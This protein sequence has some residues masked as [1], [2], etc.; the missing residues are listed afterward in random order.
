MYDWIRY[1]IF[2]HLASSATEIQTDMNSIHIGYITMYFGSFPLEHLCSTLPP[3]VMVTGLT[4]HAKNG[5]ICVWHYKC[6]WV[7]SYINII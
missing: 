6:L 2:H 7:G 3:S 1:S 5:T 4:L